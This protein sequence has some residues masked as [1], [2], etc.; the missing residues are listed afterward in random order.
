MTEQNIPANAEG[1]SKS[2]NEIKA[3]FEA[4]LTL[5]SLLNICRAAT[6]F[7]EEDDGNYARTIPADLAK[8]LEH[9]EHL[10]TNVLLGL[11]TAGAA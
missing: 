11:E 2:E 8:V 6:Y 7:L 3:A 9:A 4:G 5:C 1:L 10:A